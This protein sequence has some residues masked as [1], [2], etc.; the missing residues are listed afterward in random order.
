MKSTTKAKTEKSRI[1][2]TTVR[3]VRVLL[4]RVV[5]E[6]RAGKLSDN[7]AKTQGYLLRTLAAVIAEGDTENRLAALEKQLASIT[8]GAADVRDEETD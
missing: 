8:G 2:L 3:D 1:R 6:H 7:A 4:A 5:N